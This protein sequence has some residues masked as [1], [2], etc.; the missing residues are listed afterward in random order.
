MKAGGSDGYSV[1]PGE[2]IREIRWKYEEMVQK[3]P[4]PPGRLPML[5]ESAGE[6]G[7][8]APK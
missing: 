3:R 6:R 8:E 4:C 1:E 5:D 7:S 2:E